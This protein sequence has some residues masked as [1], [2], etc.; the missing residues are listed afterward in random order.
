M[1]PAGAPG[2]P[3]PR[4]PPGA[5]G[6]PGSNGPKGNPV[7]ISFPPVHTTQVILYIEEG[8]FK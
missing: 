5:G 8:K 1:G 2:F 6:S 7:R 4:G 3:G